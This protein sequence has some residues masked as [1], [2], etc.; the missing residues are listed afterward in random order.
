MTTPLSLIE[1]LRL[2]HTTTGHKMLG[3]AAERI[4]ELEGIIGAYRV[5]VKQRDERIAEL[6]A[7]IDKNDEWAKWF[8][9]KTDARIAEL[10]AEV[11]YA[12]LEC[13]DV[14]HGYDYEADLQETDVCGLVQ[15]MRHTIKGLRDIA[16]PDERYKKI[17]NNHSA[18]KRMLAARKVLG[19]KDD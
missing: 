11:R 1:K 7:S 3:E 16:I 14:I 12:Y 10:E 18:W 9:E 13:E 19:E 15:N 17:N 4:E 5:M 2:G 8:I 6:E